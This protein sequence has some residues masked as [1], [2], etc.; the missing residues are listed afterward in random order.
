MVV[1]YKV[2]LLLFAFLVFVFFEFSLAAPHFH[3]LVIRLL[4]ARTVLTLGQENAQILVPLLLQTLP[5]VFRAG[6][7]QFLPLLPK[8]EPLLLQ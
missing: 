1:T 7:K 6:S 5:F 4:G 2:H 8:L 3:N